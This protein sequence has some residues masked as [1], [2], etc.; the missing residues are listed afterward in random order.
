MALAGPAAH[1]HPGLRGRPA[2][3]HIAAGLVLC[4]NSV[5]ALGFQLPQK[6]ACQTYTP[7]SDAS[8]T[9]WMVASPHLYWTCVIFFVASI[10]CW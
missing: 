9:Q 8:V 2:G 6:S 10:P 4:H 3:E 1:R 5:N 7:G